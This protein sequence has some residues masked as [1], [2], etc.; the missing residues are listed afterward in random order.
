MKGGARR[1]LGLAAAAAF[2]AT[3]SDLLMLLVANAPRPELPLPPPP[4]ATLW[5]GGLLGVAAIPFYALG[6]RAIARVLQ[7][8]SLL[9]ARI[10]RGCGIGIAAFGALIHGL[11]ALS[12]QETLAAGIA[13]PPLAAIAAAGPGFLAAWAIGSLLVLVASIAIFIAGAAPDRALPRWLAWLNPAALT[14]LLALVGL[15]WEWGR[16]FLVPAAPNLAHA[17]FFAAAWRVLGRSPRLPG[18][19]AR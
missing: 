18:G 2:L 8:R 4:A 16:S 6:Y 19:S 3:L 12:I 1:G 17:L 13:P 7:P 11:T 14:L 9:S 15:P 10:V 5:L